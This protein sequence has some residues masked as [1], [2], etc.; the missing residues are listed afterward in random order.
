[1]DLAEGTKSWL[2]IHKRF[3]VLYVVEHMQGGSRILDLRSRF[4]DPSPRRWRSRVP[5]LYI[6]QLFRAWIRSSRI[7]DISVEI[8]IL[9]ITRESS[10]SPPWQSTLPQSRSPRWKTSPKSS[11]T[12]C[13]MQ[14]YFPFSIPFF[15]YPPNPFP[16]S[17]LLQLTHKDQIRHTESPQQ[18]G[19]RPRRA[20]AMHAFRQE[21]PQERLTHN[22]YLLFPNG[23][24]H[25]HRLS[26]IRRCVRKWREGHRVAGAES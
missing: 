8:A 14:R 23:A 10:G 19:H 9:I 26:R 20:N 18:P 17:H 5:N 16:L 15:S 25:V 2:S 6:T 1:M 12:L 24:H 21:I 13:V 22:T 4:Q 11:S 7:V 3:R